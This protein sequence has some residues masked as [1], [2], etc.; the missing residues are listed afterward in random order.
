ML[1]CIKIRSL[2]VTHL[3][4]P[5]RPR[6]STIILRERAPS[7]CCP[8]KSSIET[9]GSDFESRPESVVDIGFRCDWNSRTEHGFVLRP[10]GIWL[11]KVTGWSVS[12]RCTESGRHIGSS[13]RARSRRTVQM[14]RVSHSDSAFPSELISGPP[15]SRV[16]FVN[17]RTTEEF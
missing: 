10:E 13:E 8:D 15:I 17:E 7:Q 12:Y 1:I 9:R 6:R 5:A 2:L 4:N 11:F 3:S 16:E 14:F